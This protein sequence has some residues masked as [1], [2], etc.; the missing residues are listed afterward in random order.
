MAAR[1]DAAVAANVPAQGTKSLGV[2]MGVEGM[3]SDALVGAWDMAK[4]MKKATPLGKPQID[5]TLDRKG[6]VDVYDLPVKPWNARGSG[7]MKSVV[8]I[9]TDA[10]AAEMAATDWEKVKDLMAEGKYKELPPPLCFSDPEAE[11]PCTMNLA[12][13]LRV[14]D[15]LPIIVKWIQFIGGEK[16]HFV[17]DSIV[18]GNMHVLDWRKDT[19]NS[20]R[21][22][23]ILCQRLG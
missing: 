13:T 10:D 8:D 5:G 1:G 17:R 3:T 11:P 23:Q 7:S 2:H 4:G 18:R 6:S 15:G 20:A 16:S 19:F 9:V 14:A 12:V 21:T 22:M